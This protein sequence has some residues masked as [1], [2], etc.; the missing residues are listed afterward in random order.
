MI[1]LVS[2]EAAHAQLNT[3]HI[4]GGIGLKA[5][6]MPP[7]HTYVVLPLLFVY[8]TDTIRTN[9]GDRL[10]VDASI[11]ASGFG[12]GIAYVSTRRIFGGEYGAQVLFPLFMNNRLQGTEIDNET[13]VGLTDT[14]V[15]PFSVGWHFTRADAI[16]AYNLYIPTGRYADGASDNTGMG[17]WAN[18]VAFGT[19]VYLTRSKQ[20]H[21]ATM[22]S[23][24]VQSTKK[25]SDTRVGNQLV[26]EGGAGGDFLKGGLTAGLVYASGIKLS[27]DRIDRLPERLPIHKN[28]SFQLGPEVTLA[29]AAKGKVYGFL[30][31]NYQWE[32]YARNTT[33]GSALMVSSTFAVPPIK[34]PGA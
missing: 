31:V 28:R 30:K 14:L 5:G 20:Y 26:L 9:D 11:T 22:A 4:K 1:L 18:E 24:S 33:Q 17:M 23:V 8:H 19:T 6:T 15:Q 7:P 13:G 32:V 27:E 16:A 12:A 10:P 29:L 34:L 21:A 2:A 25:D 3:Q